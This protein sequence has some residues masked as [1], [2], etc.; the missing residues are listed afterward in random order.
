MFDIDALSFSL[1]LFSLSLSP[2]TVS[3]ASPT[4]HWNPLVRVQVDGAE[5][6]KREGAV[7]GSSGGGVTRLTRFFL[8]GVL[9]FVCTGALSS[10]SLAALLVSFG[11]LRSPRTSA[12]NL[13]VSASN[14]ASSSVQPG[15]TVA[16]RSGS[17]FDLRK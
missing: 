15:M 11:L 6:R 14:D 5:R 9:R 7:G 10:L 12:N 13:V 4:F 16:A 2:L 1:S 8:F 3:H 17:A